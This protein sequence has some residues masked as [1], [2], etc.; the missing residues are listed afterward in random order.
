LAFD[1]APLPIDATPRATGERG[2]IKPAAS[3]Y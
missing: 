2:S 3:G 1:A